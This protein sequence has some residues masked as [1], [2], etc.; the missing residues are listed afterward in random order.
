MEDASISKLN[1]SIPGVWAKQCKSGKDGRFSIDNVTSDG[2]K[3]NIFIAGSEM[4]SRRTVL[5]SEDEVEIRLEKPSSFSGRVVD[6]ATGADLKGFKMIRTL[7]S[8]G[9]DNGATTETSNYMQ[10]QSSPFKLNSSFNQEEMKGPLELEV[11]IM[12][13]GYKPQ[14][15]SFPLPQGEVKDMEGIEFRMEPLKRGD[16]LL[17]MT[18]LKPDGA[19]AE[20]AMAELSIY[21]H[22]GDSF[23][24]PMKDIVCGPDGSCR[25]ELPK[26][27]GSRGTLRIRHS[28]GGLI[29]ETKDLKDGAKLQLQAYAKV[30]ARWV[31]KLFQPDT[32][33]IVKT[34]SIG[35][36][37][38]DGE[39]ALIKPGPD[40][41]IT[42][43]KVTPGAFIIKGALPTSDDWM[44]GY[45]KWG[46]AKPGETLELELGKDFSEAELEIVLPEQEP[47][48][49]GANGI[50]LTM[51]VSSESSIPQKSKTAQERAE[52]RAEE[53]AEKLAMCI[54]EIKSET[55]KIPVLS[56]GARLNIFLKAG[57][58]LR[59]VE[60]IVLKPGELKGSVN[61]SGNKTI[62]DHLEFLKLPRTRS[63][64]G[65]VS[66]Q[67]GTPAEGIRIGN[68]RF[69]A[70]SSENGRGDVS[71]SS[72]EAVT[73]KGGVFQVDSLPAVK[74]INC[75][76]FA[77]EPYG[78][79][80]VS[81]DEV[82]E[83]KDIVLQRATR[84][85]GKV[86][87]PPGASVNMV[88]VRATWNGKNCQSITNN[89][90]RYA[91]NLNSAD[92]AEAEVLEVSV[93][94]HSYD[95]KFKS[96]E[97]KVKV[98]HGEDSPLNLELEAVQQGTAT[99]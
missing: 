33:S 3:L 79:K 59:S 54:A 45:S 35:I 43:D 99:K 68:F 89:G 37:S 73:G 11:R 15:R 41:L 77:N 86:K 2:M 17:F 46:T 47:K 81:F 53:G 69:N 74:R 51:S 55:I 28:S 44:D 24:D 29:V 95:G 84:V 70:G 22:F 34:D 52:K 9:G 4:Q 13:E 65:V 75:E 23:I 10:N 93:T 49:S 72:Y 16:E 94:A 57:Q 90:G 66:Y 92:Q 96:K 36:A 38:T 62:L 19:P 30:T 12:A 64:S 50:K 87:L 56:Q 88:I 97:S 1:Y 14:E 48:P 5:P 18:V 40:G 31:G 7:K 91:L 39:M 42:F 6:S 32:F 67:D 83:P 61:L 82:E 71:D 78:R 98:L 25:I 85:T 8:S 76:I 21:R 20:G 27:S 26:G 63:V 80:S 60:E 58:G